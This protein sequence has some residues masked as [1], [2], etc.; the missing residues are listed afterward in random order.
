M[1]DPSE[2][3]SWGKQDLPALQII[4]GALVCGCVFF[5]VVAVVVGQT[6]EAPDAEMRPWMTYVAVVLAAV[7]LAARMVIPGVVVAR[8]R[9][10]IAGQ[11]TEDP[12]STGAQNQLLALFRVKTILSAAII[13][14]IAFLMIV[15]YM[16]EPSPL[17]LILAVILT[18]GVATHLPTRSGVT[19][20]IEEQERLVDRQRQFG[21]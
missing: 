6:A 20:W 3:D 7:G 1:S 19:R 5:L 16:L 4:V 9:R 18:I 12:Q 21:P 8:G 14:G 17:A 11:K 2:Q 13:E 15:T 10:H